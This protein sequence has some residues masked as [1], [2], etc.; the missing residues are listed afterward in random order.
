MSENDGGDEPNPRY[1]VV[2]RCHNE[3]PCTRLKKKK[4]KRK[5][6]AIV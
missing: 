6:N 2:W 3:T 5:E 1:I 4:K